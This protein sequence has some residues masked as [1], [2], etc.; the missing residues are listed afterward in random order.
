LSRSSS[1]SKDSGTDSPDNLALLS[2]RVTLHIK[3]LILSGELAPGSRIMQEEFAERFGTSRIP[4]REA[5]RYLESEGLVTLKPNSGAWVAKLD[6]AECVEVY[7]IRERIEPLA[8]SE[9]VLRL[10]DEQIAAL[11]AS[12]ERMELSRDIEE[13]LRLDREF[14]VSS[15]AGAGMFEL[16]SLI[17]RYWN[18]TQ[19]Y[20][21]AFTR[22]VGPQGKWLINYEH[23]L[24]ME[25]IK[26]RDGEASATL[27]YGHIRRTRLALG[28]HPEL[29]TS[30]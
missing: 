11:E 26:R 30:E 25:A 21:R 24:I 3:N 14:H 9:S 1:R 18:K 23:R 15:Y 22:L 7:K 5:L 27:L 2:Q 13:F 16:L 17:H 12:V 4:V 6:L 28:E 29:F 19:Q 10:S 20:R 8:I